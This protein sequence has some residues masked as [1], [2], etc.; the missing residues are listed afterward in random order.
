MFVPW[1]HVLWMQLKIHACLPSYPHMLRGEMAWK[2]G[3]CVYKRLPN[4]I[5]WIREK[6]TQILSFAYFSQ[7]YETNIFFLGLT[8]NKNIC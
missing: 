6:L 3:V 5:A 2:V 4:A 7:V 1:L 8:I